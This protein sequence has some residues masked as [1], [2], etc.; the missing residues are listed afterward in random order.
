MRG[1]GRL[2]AHAQTH[3]QSA[4]AERLH[5]AGRVAQ[6]R[7]GMPRGGVRERPRDG[8]EHAD[9]RGD[10]RVG[11]LRLQRAV[12]GIEDRDRIG[13]DL[14]D[15]AHHLPHGRHDHRGGQ[16]AAG[17]VADRD[18]DASVVEAQRVVPVA[19]QQLA[20]ARGHVHAVE[21]DA[22]DLRQRDGQRRALKLGGGLALALVEPRVL[23]GDGGALRQ[24]FEQRQI[25]VVVAARRLRPVGHQRPDRAPVRAQRDRD[26]RARRQL[27]NHRQQRWR[28]GLVEQ[29]GLHV[30]DDHG[31]AGAQRR[32][33]GR[34]VARIVVV[35]PDQ[36][37]DEPRLVGVGVDRGDGLQA[38]VVVEEIDRR[39][40]AEV[41]HDDREQ[42]VERGLQIERLRQHLAGLREKRELLSLALVVVDVGADAEPAGRLAMRVVN[43]RHR[44][45]EP[46][47][48]SVGAPQ[49]QLEIE[50]LA[51]RQRGRDRVGGA[52]PILA[53]YP[54]PK[55]F[56]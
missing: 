38:V 3:R 33:D 36:A 11:I 49:S 52:P 39:P 25:G 10:E 35:A 45:P 15:A 4:G 47:I 48:H 31:A 44:E 42:P 43:R 40:V 27:A 55:M 34:F 51:R 24:L 6:E 50:R 21:V 30:A 12:G 1:G 13:V 8:I 56:L 16:S 2:A 29:L 14:R 54:G 53:L 37:L 22:L 26:R 41:G 23:D 5:A 17:H 32:R 20:I 18:H 7:R 46:A 9:E 28:R 19:A